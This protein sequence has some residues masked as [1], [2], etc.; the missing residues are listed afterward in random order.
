MRTT[1][2]VLPVRIVLLS[3]LLVVFPCIIDNVC[4]DGRNIVVISDGGDIIGGS[5]EMMITILL[6]L[7]NNMGVR[8]ELIP[9]K[10]FFGDSGEGILI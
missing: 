6:I 5:A 3:I 9:V 4:N 1:V 2:V 7:F 10:D 8:I